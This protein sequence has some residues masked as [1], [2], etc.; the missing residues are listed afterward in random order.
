MEGAIAGGPLEQQLN[1]YRYK[2]TQCEQERVEW[3]E[4]CEQARQQIERVQTGELEIARIKE[5]ISEL[6]K[7]LSDSHLSIY[8]EKSYLMQLKREK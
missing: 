1:F 5:Q 4:T 3:Q 2:M 8:D 6:Q 7:A